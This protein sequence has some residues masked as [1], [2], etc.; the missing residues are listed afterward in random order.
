VQF[1]L[2]VLGA[3]AATL[4]QLVHMR[5]TA[6]ELFGAE[7]FTWSAAGVGHPGQFQLAAAALML[8]GHI[9]VGL[10]DNLRVEADRRA[11]S[12][13]AL[14]EKAM[15]LAPLLDRAPANAG[16]ARRLLGLAP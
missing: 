3:N 1:V 5:R 16:E 4:E 12:N 13:A 9:R 7:R 14:V 8:G 6:V 15:A 11:D 2:G 10:E